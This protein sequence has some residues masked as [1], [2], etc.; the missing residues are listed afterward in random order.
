M[1]EAQTGKLRVNP[2]QMRTRVRIGLLAQLAVQVQDELDSSLPLLARRDGDDLVVISGHRRWLARMIAYLSPDKSISGMRDTILD[3]CSGYIEN[4]W[5]LLSESLYDQVVSMLANMDLTLPVQVWAGSEQDEVLTLIRANAGPEAPDLRGQAHAFHE[6]LG[7]GLTIQVLART[8]GLPEKM[9]QAILDSGE[10]PHVFQQ[11][12]NDELLDLSITPKLFELN[13]A[14]RT[15]LAQAT[16]AYIKEATN[17]EEDYTNLVSLAITQLQFEPPLYDRRDETPREYNSAY[18]L[19]AL[20]K[21]AIEEAPDHLWAAIARWALDYKRQIDTMQRILEL[22]G[23]VPALGDYLIRRGHYTEGVNDKTLALLPEEASCS[24][25]IFASLPQDK[26]LDKELELPCRSQQAFPQANCCTDWAPPD[27]PFHYK[28]SWWWEKG[29]KD[30]RSSKALLKAWQGQLAFEQNKPGPAAKPSKPDIED[31]RAAIRQ[32]MEQHTQPPFIL[33][34][35]WATSCTK[36][37]HHTEDSPVKSAP[38]APHCTWSKGRRQLTFD[39]LAPDEKGEVKWIIPWCRQFGPAKPWSE[40]LPEEGEAP[41]SRE[42]LVEMSRLVGRKVSTDAYSTDCRGALQFLTGRPE[43]ST[44]NHRRTFTANFDKAVKELSD[45]QLWTLL[46]W[47][48]LEWARRA[49]T[50]RTRFVPIEGT[51][52]QCRYLRFTDA[53]NWMLPEPDNDE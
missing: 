14:Q 16:E 36:C 8:A 44:A 38:D 4:E 2:A 7:R 29:Y 15:A 45:Q 18:L 12:L 28:T 31:Q 23:H 5:I 19:R 32:F 41:F 37:R 34:H 6:A 48:W 39:A 52:I 20:W 47:L 50:R 35:P 3:V 21:K 40:L 33:D 51:E 26:Y 25:C 43:K 30:L 11:L 24:N 49:G 1:L 46:Q 42:V 9:V 13:A 22:L 53:L 27:Q 17:A 10:L